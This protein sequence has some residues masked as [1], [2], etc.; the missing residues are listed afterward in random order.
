MPTPS[1]A[2]SG[3]EAVRRLTVDDA[4]AAAGCPPDEVFSPRPASSASRWTRR[5][6]HGCWT[7]SSPRPRRRLARSGARHHDHRHLPE[8]RHARRPASAARRSTINGIAKGAGM[9][10]PDMA[11]M[12]A[13]VFTDAAI[14]AS[15]LQALLRSV[16]ERTFNCITVD[17]DTST[18]DTLLRSRP[19]RRSARAGLAHGDDPRLRRVRGQAC[20]PSLADLACQVVRDGEGATQVRRPSTSRARLESDAA[21][22]IGL[23]DRQLAA[24]QDGDC[25]RRRQLGPHRHGGGQGR[26]AGRPRPALDLVRRHPRRPK[27][28]RDPGTT[29]KRKVSAGDEGPEDRPQ[30][31]SSNSATGRDRV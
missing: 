15:V 21:R 26:R 10:A 19:A 28:E 9:I 30:G 4:A 8:A 17:G 23:V 22:R 5:N 16:A 6:S 7:G 13:F 25:R 27:G 24:G 18:S 20:A 2:R 29:T 31:R 3:R 14:A 1:P 11:T 12:L